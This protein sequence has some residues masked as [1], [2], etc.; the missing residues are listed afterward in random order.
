MLISALG[1]MGFLLTH[2]KSALISGLASGIIMIVL[3]FF[4]SNNSVVLAAR[5]VN[6]LLLAVFGWR[7]FLAINAVILGN[8]SKL[9]PAL[10]ITSMAV[11]S[12]ITLTLSLKNKG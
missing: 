5:I 9:I 11:I 2:A 7:S 6:G 8:I 10:L 1:I 4:V 3:S 12:L